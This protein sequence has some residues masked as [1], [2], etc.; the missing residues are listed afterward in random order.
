M[1]RIIANKPIKKGD[2]LGTDNLSLLRSSTGIPAKYWDL[3][4]GKAA[5]RDYKEDEPIEF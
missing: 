2:I 3:V 4:A 1:K 5:K